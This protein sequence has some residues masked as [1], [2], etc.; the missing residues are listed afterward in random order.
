MSFLL[1]SAIIALFLLPLI[2]NNGETRIL[3][4][5]YYY[6][7]S[8]NS[9]QT[10]WLAYTH[11]FVITGTIAIGS[12]TFDILVANCMI[13]ICAQLDVLTYRI[14]RI[15]HVEEMNQM[16]QIVLCSVHYKIIFRF[17]KSLTII[18]VF[19]SIITETKK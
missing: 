8:V 14:H 4:F 19:I 5:P 16:T 10:Y 17:E 3:P 9:S 18:K 12:L 7:F 11:Q 1:I 13:Q 6:Q 2:I 15:S